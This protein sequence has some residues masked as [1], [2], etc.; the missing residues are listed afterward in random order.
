M[1]GHRSLS[2]RRPACPSS[3]DLLGAGAGWL[4]RRPRFHP[5]RSPGS[6]ELDRKQR[7]ARRDARAT[8]RAIGGGRSR[9]RRSTGLSSAPLSKIFRCRS[10]VCGFSK[11]APNSASRSAT[12]IR[13]RKRARAPRSK[14]CSAPASRTKPTFNIHFANF[15]IGARRRLGIRFLGTLPAQCRSF[16]RQYAGDSRRLRQR[17]R[18]PHR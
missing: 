7:Q 5:A 13:K 17:S 16:R 8:I 18:V 10:P 6:K 11:R 1:G 9:I 12:C 2:A 3:P 14:T 4:R 15:N